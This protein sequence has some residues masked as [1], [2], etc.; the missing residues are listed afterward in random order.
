MQLLGSNFR[1][2]FMLG[3]ELEI[4]RSKNFISSNLAYIKQNEFYE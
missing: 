3:T 1:K 2:T 4:E